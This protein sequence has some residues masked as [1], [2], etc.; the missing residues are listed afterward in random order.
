M[1]HVL[2][3]KPFEKRFK[4]LAYLDQMGGAS[5]KYLMVCHAEYGIDFIAPEDD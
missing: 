2:E 3:S 4:Q 1:A 5:F